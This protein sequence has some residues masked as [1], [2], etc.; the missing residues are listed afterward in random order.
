MELQAAARSA[1]EVRLRSTPGQ[2]R[3]TAERR[4]PAV[5]GA[6]PR[7]GAAARWAGRS[8]TAPQARRALRSLECPI[9]R[10]Q[11]GPMQTRLARRPAGSAEID[12]M[13]ERRWAARREQRPA[14]PPSPRRLVQAPRAPGRPTKARPADSRRERRARRRGVQTLR[15]VRVASPTTAKVPAGRPTTALP[16][17]GLEAA[18]RELPRTEQ[19][20]RQEARPAGPSPTSARRLV[21]PPEAVLPRLEKMRA[22]QMRR[23]HPR[24]GRRRPE[25]VLKLQATPPTPNHQAPAVPAQLPNR[26]MAAVRPWSARRASRVQAAPRLPRRPRS[27][28]PVR[29]V[30]LEART[31]CSC[32][33]GEFSGRVR[34]RAEPPPQG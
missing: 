16:G 11:V 10:P 20:P 18:P 26:A 31:S 22:A 2:E 3:S 27:G 7:L 28:W 13:P 19:A 15:S 17:R 1:P 14:E 25:A 32:A 24:K 8:T 4:S 30:G 5:A 33:G 23:E 29:Q 21:P 12:P 9:L 34:R 6:A